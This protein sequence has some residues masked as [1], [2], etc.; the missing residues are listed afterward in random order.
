MREEKQE[1]TAIRYIERNPVKVR[2]CAPPEEWPFA[3]ARFRNQYQQLLI[4]KECQPPARRQ[5]I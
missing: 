3:S 2:L 5:V 1:K 4:P